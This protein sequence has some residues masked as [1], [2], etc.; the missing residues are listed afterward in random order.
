MDT[1]GK[2]I[3]EESQT[4]KELTKKL[5]EVQTKVYKQKKKQ[6]DLEEKAKVESRENERMKREL[7]ILKKKNEE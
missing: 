4:D 7:A 3:Q 2:Q 6:T 1:I 5:A